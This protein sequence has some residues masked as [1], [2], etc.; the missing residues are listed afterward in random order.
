MTTIKVDDA[1][2]KELH[3]KKLH[4]G[5]SSLNEVIKSLLQGELK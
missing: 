5:Y 2:V 4:Y 3:L 1:V